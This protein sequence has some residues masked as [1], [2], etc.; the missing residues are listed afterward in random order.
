MEM[1]N[2]SINYSA[3]NDSITYSNNTI[4]CDWYQAC[5]YP[6]YQPYYVSYPVYITD[7][8]KFEKAFRVAK[9]LL[10][11]KLLKSRKLK[12]FIGLVEKIAKEL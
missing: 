11:E 3:T 6:Y 9:L 1:A 10:K 8:D 4:N 12:D 2:Q 5:W 7:K